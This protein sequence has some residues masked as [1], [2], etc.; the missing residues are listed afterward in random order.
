MTTIATT[1]AT[2]VGTRTYQMDKAHSEAG[3]QVRHLLSKVR[4]HFSEFDGQI[5]FDPDAPEQGTVQF[6]IQAASINTNEPKRDAHL[7]SED[8]FAVDQHPTLTFVSR[9][10]AK[11]NVAEYAVEGDL[12][13]RGVT[14]PVTLD[15]TYLGAAKDPW[16]NERVAFEAETTLNRKD[17]GLTW[18]AALETGGFLVGD[19]V[20]VLLSIQALAK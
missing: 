17:F 8:F 16:G 3:F 10:V 6:S 14:R 9:A 2:P 13:I 4:G 18:N 1:T 15:V 11:T 5:T 20:R 7:R 12:T 19:E